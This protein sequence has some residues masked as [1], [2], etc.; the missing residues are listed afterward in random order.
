MIRSA[1]GRVVWRA[2]NMITSARLNSLTRD[3]VRQKLTYLTP[4]KLARLEASA[5]A[6]MENQIP[7][8]LLE[9]GVALGGSAII[10][11]DFAKLKTLGDIVQFYATRLPNRSGQASPSSNGSKIDNLDPVS[12]YEVSSVAVREEKKN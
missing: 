4:Q 7:G 12:R 2:N 1:I 3:V 11:A 8:D 5:S 9:F 10:L 6:V